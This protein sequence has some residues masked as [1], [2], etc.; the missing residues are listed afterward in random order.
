MQVVPVDTHGV[1]TKPNHRRLFVF[2]MS[3]QLELKGKSM[4]NEA[5]T[6]FE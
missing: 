4:R 3:G 5:M 1:H 6:N 2:H